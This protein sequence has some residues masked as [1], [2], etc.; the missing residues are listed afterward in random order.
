MGVSWT[1][2]EAGHFTLRLLSLTAYIY[3]TSAPAADATIKIAPI[4]SNLADSPVS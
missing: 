2:R 1:E 3:Y 4:L